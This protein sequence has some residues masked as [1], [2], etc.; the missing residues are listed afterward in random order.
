M[1]DCHAHLWDQAFAKDKAEIVAASR[2]YGIK[3]VCVSSLGVHEPDE[4]EISR[5]N[6]ASWQFMQEEPD[7]IRGFCYVNPRYSSSLAELRLCIEDRGMLGLKLWVA[8]FCNEPC[9][10]HL[11]EYCIEKGLPVLIHAWKKTVGQLP[12]EST[13][14]HVAD[15]ARRYPEANLIMAHLGG[16]SQHELR[17]I[18]PYSNISTDISGSLY[19]NADLAYA[20][21]LLG[22]ERVLFGSDMPGASFLVCQGQV[23]DAELDQAEKQLILAGNAQRLIPGV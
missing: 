10:F 14:E 2:R 8:S 22:A 4:A 21:Q 23:E 1:I 19:R 11:V 9:V 7:L 5:L 13:A 18:Q 16:N 12:F 6:T 17:I 20:V 15:L 3:R